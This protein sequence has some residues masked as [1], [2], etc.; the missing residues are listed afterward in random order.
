MSGDIG[1]GRPEGLRAVSAG[2][3]TMNSL[4]L[5]SYAAARCRSLGDELES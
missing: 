4:A 2:G 5:T 1:G 3:V